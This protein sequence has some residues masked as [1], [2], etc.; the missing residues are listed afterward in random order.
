[1]SATH[2]FTLHTSKFDQIY[3]EFNNFRQKKLFKVHLQTFSAIT[4]CDAMPFRMYETWKR[5]MSASCHYLRR[6]FHKIPEAII[7]T[8]PIEKS[9]NATYR[10]ELT[11]DMYP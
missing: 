6:V 8:I 1:M 5:R 10:L 11:N 3:T 7:S 9:I 2:H 4:L